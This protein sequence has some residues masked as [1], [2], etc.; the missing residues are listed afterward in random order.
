MPNISIETNT[1]Q[2]PQTPR[3]TKQHK[4]QNKKLP[5]VRVELTIFFACGGLD[6]HYNWPTSP[7][8][9]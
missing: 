7:T 6:S 5:T 2:T 4:K 1:I 8:R 3:N 9:P